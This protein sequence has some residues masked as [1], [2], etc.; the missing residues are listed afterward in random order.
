[1]G[2]EAKMDV[3]QISRHELEKGIMDEKFGSL[4]FYAYCNTPWHAMGVQ[5]FLNHF[6]SNRKSVRGII[7]ISNQ[8]GR[9]HLLSPE[10]FH[11]GSNIQ[12][13]YF[14][15]KESYRD[16]KGKLLKS[17][18][19]SKHHKI[20]K[21]SNILYVLRPFRP[22]IRFGA[23]YQL[24]TRKKSKL[25]CLD[26]GVGTYKSNYEI[27]SEK[28]KGNKK[29]ALVYALGSVLNNFLKLKYDLEIQNY[30]LFKKKQNALTLNKKVANEY[31]QLLSIGKEPIIHSN[32][33]P[34][35]ILV[36]QPFEIAQDVACKS[37]INACFDRIKEQLEAVGVS[38][39]IKPHPREDKDILSDYKQRGYS[40]IDS[41][42]SL[43]KYLEYVD[44][45]PIIVFGAISTALVTASVLNNIIALSIVCI[46][47]SKLT[48]E[49][50]KT[51]KNFME[52]YREFVRFPR[53]DEELVS[54][55]KAEHGK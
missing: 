36:T 31:K 2:S 21:K 46:D 30:T 32:K 42:L 26:E 51:A 6:F 28:I 38:V 49:Y 10:Q 37:V 19:F 23:E 43:E 45:K 16:N 52:R 13:L 29:E 12:A 15:N 41:R 5:S 7:F 53:T 39:F 50:N 14:K 48:R 9:P 55:V 18:L 47:S 17:L 22:D 40:V 34:Y 3:L 1:M 20:N 33:S 25:V 27:F 35:V 44:H 24:N 8:P 11:L 4:D 54:E